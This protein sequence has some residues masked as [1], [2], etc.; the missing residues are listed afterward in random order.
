MGLVMGT[1]SMQSKPVN[2]H[3]DFSAQA[4]WHHDD[5]GDGGCGGYADHADQAEEAIQ[6]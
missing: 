3:K 1:F 2:Y 4:C 6:G 5:R